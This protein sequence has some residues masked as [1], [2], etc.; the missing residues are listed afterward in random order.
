MRFLQSGSSLRALACA[1]AALLITAS[2]AFA[3]TG[4]KAGDANNDGS[5][6]AADAQ[7]VLTAL[8]ELTL[9]AGFT[10]TQGDAN[11]D[12]AL[13]AVDAQIILAHVVGITLSD[14]CVGQPMGAPVV[15]I[16]MDSTTASVVTGSSV[17]LTAITRDSANSVLTGRAL[18]WKSSN[19]A[20]ATVS[21]TG[22]VT[23]R[24]GGSVT[25][26]ATTQGKTASATVTVVSGTTLTVKLLPDTASVLVG[27]NVTINT[28]VLDAAGNE[29]EGKKVTWKSSD[30]TK[31]KIDK[32][33][34]VVVGVA[35]GTVSMTA[36]IDNVVYATAIVT[37]VKATQANLTWVGGTTGAATS[38]TTASNWSPARVPVATD[39]VRIPAGPSSMPV[40]S[41][42]T[43]IAGL[44][45]D[46]TA[47]LTIGANEMQITGLAL[48]HGTLSG[49]ARVSIQGV[50]QGTSYVRG[51]FPEI[52]I[53]GNTVL[54]GSLES[55]GSLEA[56]ATARLDLNGYSVK[57]AGNFNM[58][59]AMVM[60][61]PQEV[62]DIDG[63]AR[64]FTDGSPVST[65]TDGVIRVGGHFA[66][67]QSH[68]PTTTLNPFSASG[69]HRLVLDGGAKQIVADTNVNIVKFQELDLSNSAGGVEFTTSPADSTLR[70]QVLGHLT[71]TRAVDISGNGRVNAFRNVYLK[72]GV[73]TL[74]NLAVG[75]ILTAEGTFKPDTLTF[76]GGTT[77]VAQ[78]IPVGAPYQYQSVVGAGIGSFRGTTNIAG[79]LT[80][81]CLTTKSDCSLAVAPQLTLAGSRVFVGGNLRQTSNDPT[82][83][84]IMTSASD[85][86]VVTGGVL[87]PVGYT[88]GTQT[89]FNVQ[90][91]DWTAGILRVGGGFYGSGSGANG[92]H[93]TYLD[94]GAQQT[95]RILTG[96]NFQELNIANTGGVVMNDSLSFGARTRVVGVLGNFNILTASTL[97]GTGRINV[98]GNLNTN[99]GSNVTVSAISMGSVQRVAGS[100]APDTSEFASSSIVQSIQLLSGYKHVIVSGRAFAAGS[101]TFNGALNVTSTGQ[102]NLEGRHLTVTGNAFVSGILRMQDV[103]DTLTI[104]GDTAWFVGGAGDRKTYTTAGLI[105]VA[106]HFRSDSL[107]LHPTGSHT[108]LFATQ[109]GKVLRGNSDFFLGRRP[110]IFQNLEVRGTGTGT[111]TVRNVTVRDVVVRGNFTASQGT[112]RITLDTITVDGDA[113]ITQADSVIVPAGRGTATMFGNSLTFLYLRISSDVTVGILASGGDILY[114]AGARLDGTSALRYYGNYAEEGVPV[115]Q[116]TP[117]SMRVNSIEFSSPPTNTTAG[118][119]F[120]P[121]VTALLKGSD[122]APITKNVLVTVVNPTNYNG[123]TR[124]I[125]SGGTAVFTDLGPK[126]TG[127]QTLFVQVGS[128]IGTISASAGFTAN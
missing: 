97:S 71:G 117:L 15:T 105:R 38:W 17:Q 30:T 113:V 54:V 4:P 81:G 6:S 93:V 19:T 69:R 88:L 125:S 39:T 73:V 45:I 1:A 63:N 66:V 65:L 61:E 52:A 110:A 2:T 91:N 44:I 49:T 83:R 7:A 60:K 75:R 20:V 57:V 13:T 124:A 36:S 115:A 118:A 62:V 95:L 32:D 56:I 76:T 114:K 72:G 10:A 84:L 74:R 25:I 92:T 5:I 85:S 33:L 123:T 104:S 51:R 119:A 64:F 18:T 77:T 26:T 11:C 126:N 29:V 89:F 12:G 90:L 31:A 70:F 98:A 24:A 96:F 106:G 28:T 9:P 41:Q 35:P 23:G 8:V 34:G 78:G 55:L 116:G 79:G 86:L 109:N 58:K 53:N 127:A 68:P 22:L 102:L 112:S 42:Y 82:A 122:N 43:V 48:V 107:T 103:R 101:M 27:G 80:I 47:T 67:V 94:G 100:W 37:V 99:P 111:D 3:Q 87:G 120:S 16:S 21:N 59:G 40:I 46:S 50:N 108:V 121:T 14:Y 128:A